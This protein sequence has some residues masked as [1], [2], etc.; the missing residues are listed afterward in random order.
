MALEERGGRAERPKS[1]AVDVK[2]NPKDG[3]IW[4][5]DFDDKVVTLDDAGDTEYNRQRN[6]PDSDPAPDYPRF[7]QSVSMESPPGEAQEEGEDDA[8]IASLKLSE[9]TPTDPPVPAPPESKPPEVVVP[10]PAPEPTPI[11][12]PSTPPDTVVALAS[13]ATSTPEPMPTLESTE[14]MFDLSRFELQISG[15]RTSGRAGIGAEPPHYRYKNPDGSYRVDQFGVPIE[16]PFDFVEDLKRGP[17]PE[18]AEPEKPNQVARPPEGSDGAANEEGQETAINW[19]KPPRLNDGVKALTQ[20][21]IQASPELERNFKR[22]IERLDPERAGALYLK[23]TS[24][25]ILDDPELA[26]LAYARNEF[27]NRLDAGTK[28]ATKLN[29]ADVGTGRMR[30]LAFRNEVDMNGVDKTLAEMRK[31]TLILAMKM[32]DEELSRVVR[33]YETLDRDRSTSE[34]KQW[35]TN[36]HSVAQKT[37]TRWD[38]YSEKISARVQ[39]RSGRIELRHEAEKTIAK[40]YGAF[41]NVI[42]QFNPFFDT[43]RFSRADRVVQTADSV[44]RALKEKPL[45]REINQQL[46]IITDFMKLTLNHDPEVRRAL[47]Q[48]AARNA[49]ISVPN[50]GPGTFSEIQAAVP[51]ERERLAGNPSLSPA[52]MQPWFVRDRATWRTP[53]GRGYAQM[54]RQEI[55]ERVAAWD[56]PE[57]QQLR[58]RERQSR[59]GSIMAAIIGL[60]FGRTVDQHKQQLNLA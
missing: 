44:E 28:L 52:T 6:E 2:I 56:P 41:R 29:K 8:V 30:S 16:Y 36:V 55:N 43:S 38:D 24:G 27:A 21:E 54:N 23:W 49:A 42:A 39:S 14:P 33:A 37:G 34:Y 3:S 45:L 60:L 1:D 5:L 26:V 9:P 40:K 58:E 7:K 17:R 48:A 19:S 35:E 10:H 13:A 32:T 50:A 18:N 25:E 57:L 47:Q 20:A 15:E 46:A 53:D 11:I 4:Y 59:G 51:G 22:T 12:V 31:Q